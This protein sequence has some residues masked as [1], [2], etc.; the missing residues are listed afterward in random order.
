MKKWLIIYT[1]NTNNTK[2]IAEA[3]A[4]VAGEGSMMLSSKEVISVDDYDIIAIGFWV[5]RGGPD[6][7]TQS[8]LPKIKNK[9]VILF[10]TLGADPKS[11]HAITSLAKAA[12]LLGENCS[13]LGTFS[14]QGKIN[15]V[16]LDKRKNLAPDNPHAHSEENMR[17]WASAA[18]HPN[19][20]D[21]ENAKEFVRKI[22][23]KIKMREKFIMAKKIFQ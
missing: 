12:Y 3:M 2:K 7:V 14:A 16:L 9:Q 10:Q 17:R 13:I 4:S 6:P 1:S 21:L 23:R 5:T 20:E 11:E 15:P 22:E 19:E 18:N 8:L